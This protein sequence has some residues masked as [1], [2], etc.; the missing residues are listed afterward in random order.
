MSGMRKDE[1][2]RFV[3]Q[4][5]TR[6]GERPHWDLMLE[7]G[8]VLETYRVCLPPEDWGYKPMEAVRIFDHP[9][10]F[11]SYEGSVNKGKGRV[12]I[13]DAGTYCL[14]TQNEEQ[15]QLSFTGKLLKGKF[16]FCLIESDRWEI[17]GF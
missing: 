15:R 8:T 9:L 2:L 5:H 3:I 16:K 6:D 13:A 7:R 4:R 11:L 12:E 10:K 14:L 1:P 17:I